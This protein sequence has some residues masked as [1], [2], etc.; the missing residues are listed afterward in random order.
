[1]QVKQSQINRFIITGHFST[2]LGNVY[3]KGDIP[4]GLGHISRPSDI[5]QPSY[6]VGPLTLLRDTQV[7]SRT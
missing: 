3:E 1:M 6:D 5:A 4:R 2:L 7:L